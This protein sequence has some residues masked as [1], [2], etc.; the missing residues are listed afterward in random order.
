MIPNLSPLTVDYRADQVI[1]NAHTMPTGTIA[2]QALNIPRECISQILGHTPPLT[3]MVKDLNNRICS[4]ELLEPAKASIHEIISLMQ[5]QPPFCYL[6]VEI[7]HQT[8]DALF[9]PEMC[10]I[11]PKICKINRRT[12]MDETTCYAFI[13]K[14]TFEEYVYMLEHLGYSLGQYLDGMTEFAEALDVL[15]NRKPDDVIV[16]TPTPEEKPS[17]I[18]GIPIEVIRKA[19]WYLKLDRH[20]EILEARLAINMKE[21]EVLPITEQITFEELAT[22]YGLTGPSSIQN[23]LEKALQAMGEYLW[24]L[25]WAQAVKFQRISKTKNAAVYQ[26][27]A[28]CDGEWGEI[29]FDL[30]NGTATVRTVA[31]WDSSQSKRYANEVIRRMNDSGKLPKSGTFYFPWAT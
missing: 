2:C 9:R 23:G 3:A 26:Y 1:Y 29:H 6:D 8:I 19:F 14:D 20:R 16:P 4:P 31:E 27:Q 30:K 28:D 5:D 11:Y 17:T 12:A 22:R 18:S 7:I 21:G 24:G 25:G 15:E 13:L 10:D